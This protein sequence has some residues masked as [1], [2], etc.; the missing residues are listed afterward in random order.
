MKKIISAVCY[1]H[2]LGL[3]HNDLTPMNIMVDKCNNPIII[4]FGSCQPFG[5]IL[6]T[7]GTPGWIHEDFTISAQKHDE[8]ALD[9]IRRWLEEITGVTQGLETNQRMFFARK[10]TYPLDMASSITMPSRVS[11]A[12]GEVFVGCT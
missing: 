8:S 9:K 12:Q 11:F 6:I 5:S 7:A 10:F 1:L 4:D 2:S 3:A